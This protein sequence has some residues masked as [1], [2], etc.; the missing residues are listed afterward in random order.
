VYECGGRGGDPSTAFWKLLQPNPNNP[1]CI[2]GLELTLAQDIHFRVSEELF[3]FLN[4]LIE[5]QIAFN[6]TPKYSFVDLHIGKC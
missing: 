6:L 2:I 4:P 3:Q 1:T 5:Q